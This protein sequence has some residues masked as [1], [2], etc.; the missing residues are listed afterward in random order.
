MKLTNKSI[1][2]SSILGAMLISGVAH[3]GF[4]GGA[5][6]GVRPL[7]ANFEKFS[8]LDVKVTNLNESVTKPAM[9]LFVGFQHTSPSG[10]YSATEIFYDYM[11]MSA[12]VSTN[13][14][15]LGSNV[16]Q[17]ASANLKYNIGLSEL[18]GY[19]AH[20][21][22]IIYGRVGAIADEL[23]YKESQ[24]VGNI[25]RDSEKGQ[26]YAGAVQL[27]LGIVHPLTKHLSVRGEY[28]Y[29]RYPNVNINLPVSLPGVGTGS[30][31]FS[32]EVYINA[33]TL[34]LIYSF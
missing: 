19:Q 16:A 17:T 10:F 23:Y 4:Y 25:Y 11:N 12:Q 24:Q 7:S 20:N 15:I 29:T 27:G 3:A 21:G 18:L 13:I 22:D 14:D 6:L 2:V 26:H 8:V 28:T 31:K 30:V 32:P 33:A 1:F 5:G 9:N 34:S